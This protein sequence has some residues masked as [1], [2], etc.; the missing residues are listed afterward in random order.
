MLPIAFKLFAPNNSSY[1]IVTKR[2]KC[3]NNFSLQNS[4]ILHDQTVTMCLKVLVKI[5]F[6]ATIRVLY[7]NFACYLALS[8]NCVPQIS[9]R[10]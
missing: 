6:K 1:T 7:Y 10:L 4:D 5:I 2:L 8:K 9:S 3:L